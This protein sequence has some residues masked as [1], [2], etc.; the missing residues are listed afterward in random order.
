M[1]QASAA[2]SHSA[3]RIHALKTPT[4]DDDGLAPPCSDDDNLEDFA[5]VCIT[6]NHH[7]QQDPMNYR[8]FGKSSGV[9]LVQ[10]AIDLKNEFS[11]LPIG[12]QQLQPM[13]GPNGKRPEFWH[14]RPVSIHLS[15]YFFWL[16]LTCY[17]SGNLRSMPA[18]NTPNMNFQKMTSWL[19]WS[20]CTSPTRI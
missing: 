12:Q 10:T 5:K 7:D 19:S 16:C 4:F 2:S 20:I 18:P 8:F 15:Y 3:L 17:P 14:V 6:D 1:V 13:T 9:V 11:G